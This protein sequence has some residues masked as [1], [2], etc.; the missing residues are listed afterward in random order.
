MGNY[1]KNGL[2]VDILKIYINPMTNRGFTGL[3][4]VA[5]PCCSNCSQYT[6]NSVVS[7]LNICSRYSEVT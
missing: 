7:I 3:M 1:S 2:E 5:A 6:K 4:G